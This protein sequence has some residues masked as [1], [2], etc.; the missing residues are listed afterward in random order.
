MEAR[1]P[2]SDSQELTQRNVYIL[3]TRAGWM[4][5]LTLLILLI[6]AINYQIN[7]GY[8]LTFMLAGAAAVGMYSCHNNLRGI[9]LHL[10]L[11]AAVF[12]GQAVPLK[13]DLAQKGKRPR[14]GIGMALLDG[15]DWAWVDVPAQGSASVQLAWP[16]VQRG[17]QACPTLSA[18]THYPL[19]HFRVWTVWCPASQILVY[20]QP[21][22]PVPTLPAGTPTQGGQ[23]SASSSASGEFDG[24]RPY[25]RGD[26]RKAIVWK[27]MAKGGEL[28]S[29]DS[30]QLHSS[31][32]CLD[33]HYTGAGM[34]KEARLSRL[35]AWVLAAH[36]ADLSY[37]LR[38]PHTEIAAD[39]GAAQRDKC[40]QALA[41]A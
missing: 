22:N 27:K 37:S 26:A 29:R 1:L 24:V 31:E 30:Q 16:A 12:A 5:L 3:P 18:Q 21:E 41:L 32:L 34:D 4:L 7:L 9:H 36:Q 13:I 19:G 6:A 28:V 17:W 35:A 33:Y 14:Y 2:R 11:P 38:L 15:E 25:R 40:L 8:L 10:Q 20:P 39:S 23:A